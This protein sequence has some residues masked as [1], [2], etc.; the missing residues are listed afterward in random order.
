MVVLIVITIFWQLTLES[1]YK[2]L[3]QYL[4]LTLAER[5][6]QEREG[7]LD[8]TDDDHS[9]HSS[10]A[11]HDHHASSKEG[12]LKERKAGGSGSPHTDAGTSSD[13]QANAGEV[14]TLPGDEHTDKHAFD[15]DCMHESQQIVWLPEDPY[16]FYRHEVAATRAAR[17]D[18]S[19][20][21]AVM[22]EKG[23]ADVERSPPGMP[24]EEVQINAPAQ[25]TA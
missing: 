22:N 8:S 7:L 16:G 23:K 18:V 9:S 19:T 17:V 2:P 1:G 25:R 5:M 14:K 4:P 12:E 11:Q 10:G 13:R 21:G 15:H 20:E 24:W 6:D 3:I